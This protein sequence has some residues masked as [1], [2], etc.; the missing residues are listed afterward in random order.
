MSNNATLVFEEV[1]GSLP[2]NVNPFLALASV[3][4]NQFYPAIPPQFEQQ[5]FALSGIFIMYVLPVSLGE[6]GE[7]VA[8]LTT[9]FCASEQNVHHSRRVVDHPGSEA[10]KRLL[11]LSNFNDDFWFVHHA[12]LCRFV[13]SSSR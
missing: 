8:D 13:S 1:L 12:S 7:Q 9:M 3:V 4:T 10:G 2:P 6:K 11:G 5:L